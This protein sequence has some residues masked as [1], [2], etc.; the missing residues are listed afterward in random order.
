MAF[1]AVTP[2]TPPQASALLSNNAGNAGLTNTI[3]LD[4]LG[5][6]EQTLGNLLTDLPTTLGVVA[7]PVAK[8]TKNTTSGTTTA[9]AGDMTGA[10][11]VQV[12]YSAV[13]AANLVTRTAVQLVADVPGVKVGDSYTLLV[14]NT[15]G[16]T[17]TITAGTGVTLTGTMTLATNTTRLFNVKFVS[18]T[19]VT[20][21]SISIG[22]IA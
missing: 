7:Q 3:P 9:A 18:L 14:I 6:I 11:Y 17:T 4:R 5:E 13:G 22:T 2:T 20:I 10:G 1:P 15:S 16:G 8:Y 21:Q 19:A 12:E